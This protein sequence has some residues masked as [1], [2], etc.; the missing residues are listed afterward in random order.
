MDHELVID[1][2]AVA[3]GLRAQRQ[4]RECRYAE[5]RARLEVRALESQDVADLLAVIECAP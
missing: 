5:A 4:E 2:S 3:D 1:L